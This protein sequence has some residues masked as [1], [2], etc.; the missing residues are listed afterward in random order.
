MMSSP[1]EVIN[2][3]TNKVR[4]N[5]AAK[6]AMVF[7]GCTACSQQCAATLL[8]GGYSYTPVLA[9]GIKLPL[10]ACSQQCLYLYGYTVQSSKLTSSSQTR[11]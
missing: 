6:S 5:H 4:L 1:E 10:I 11:S 7:P 9:A 2:G 3:G 8:A